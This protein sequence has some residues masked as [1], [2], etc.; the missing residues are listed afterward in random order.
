MDKGITHFKYCGSCG[1]KQIYK[2]L[3]DLN[4]AIKKNTV[5]PLCANKIRN[6]PSY[7]KDIP[8]AWFESVKRNAKK[9]KIEFL[10][11]IQYIYRIYIKQNKECSL[12][13]VPLVFDYEAKNSNVSI[14]RIDSSKPYAKR[15]IQLVCKDINFAKWVFPQK[16][17]IKLC[18][19]VAE[20]HKDK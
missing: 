2:C 5:C 17:F 3:G 6:S 8:I 9:R 4:K 14:D 11:D 18:K 19:L 15:N 13:G 20:K 10:I 12:T 1:T 7:Y 16:Y